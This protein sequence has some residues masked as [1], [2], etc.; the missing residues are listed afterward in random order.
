MVIIYKFCNFFYPTTKKTSRTSS[1][2]SSTRKVEIKI[3][4]HIILSVF[5]SPGFYNPNYLDIKKKIYFKI[6]QNISIGNF[7]TS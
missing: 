5:F 1:K 4:Y 2:W 3:Q 6:L 7:Q